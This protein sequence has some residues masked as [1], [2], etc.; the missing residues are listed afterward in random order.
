MDNERMIKLQHFFSVDVK[1]KKELF[2]IAPQS[3]DGYMDEESVSKY[4]DKLNDS[5]IYIFNELKCVTL[6]IFGKDSHVFKRICLLEKN[7]MESFYNC[8]FDI[9]KLKSFYQKY[10]SNMEPAFIDSVKSKCF[11]YYI[12]YSTSPADEATSINEILHFIHSYIINN[13]KIL[14]SIPLL[15]K[16]NNSN[17]Y[18]ISL[19]GVKS[20]IF[21]QIFKMFPKDLTGGCTDMVAI[22]DKKLI[23]MI[24]GRGH[25]L[26]IEVT[27]NNNIARIE[28]FIPKLC[29]IEMINNLPGVNKVNKN[30]I[31]ATG[32]IETPINT[33]PG[34]LFDFISKVPTDYDMVNDFEEIKRNRRGKVM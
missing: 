27:L 9:N 21:K 5:L 15:K 4:T 3:L 28:Y 29:N 25:A 26:T 31:G 20:P 17:N 6:D 23:I 16:K 19:R 33:L 10:I 8:G 7:T 24:R 22:N 34:V 30:S 18:P 12:F 14:Q 1:I 2:D 11:G 32:V 13:E